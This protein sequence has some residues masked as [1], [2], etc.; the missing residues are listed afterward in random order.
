M[1][2]SAVDRM[3]RPLRAAGLVP[4]GEKGR[5]KERGHYQVAHIVNL[6][7]AMAAEHHNQAAD[8]VK[9]LRPLA[10]ISVLPLERKPAFGKG[11][12]GQALEQMLEQT[13]SGYG[14]LPASLELCV[15]PLRADLKWNADDGSIAFGRADFYRPKSFTRAAPSY[16]RPVIIYAAAISEISDLLRYEYP[17]SVSPSGSS[18]PTTTDTGNENAALPQAAPRRPRKRVAAADGHP[19]P[20]TTLTLSGGEKQHAVLGHPQMGALPFGVSSYEQHAP[21]PSSA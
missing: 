12:L 3:L 17:L 2:P 5:G 7:L 15:D 10:A 11:N 8:A 16:E 18:V 19:R 13:S 9:A 6:I 4:M 20:A 14:H 21:S 1:Q